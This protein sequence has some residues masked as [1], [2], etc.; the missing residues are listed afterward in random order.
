MQQVVQVAVLP[1]S[2]IRSKNEIVR[3][4]SATSNDSSIDER[5]DNNDLSVPQQRPVN[6]KVSRSVALDDHIV[7]LI[8][9]KVDSINDNFKAFLKEVRGI[10]E[11]IGDYVK[12]RPKGENVKNR[13]QSGQDEELG[14]QF[15]N[16]KAE[17][18]EI[19]KTLNWSPLDD[20]MMHSQVFRKAANNE[21]QS[22]EPTKRVSTS[23]LLMQGFSCFKAKK[24]PQKSY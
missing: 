11:E 5:E 19:K 21:R 15:M 22:L 13:E 16:W 2:S 6:S 12:P 3:K 23:Y 4:R 9:S 18:Q 17:A 1:D 7:K 24:V 10:K 20:I 14:E 8:D